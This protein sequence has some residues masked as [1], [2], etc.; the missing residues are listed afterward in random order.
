MRTVTAY[1]ELFRFPS[2]LPLL[3]VELILD[4]HTVTFYPPYAEIEEAALFPI[5]QVRG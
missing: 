5:N 4:G 2:M 3:E 1:V